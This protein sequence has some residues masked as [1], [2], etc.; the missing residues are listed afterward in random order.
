[1]TWTERHSYQIT[2]V[3]LKAMA[4]VNPNLA[5]PQATAES[6]NAS[7]PI[8][9]TNSVL[10]SEFDT[11]KEILRV[12]LQSWRISSL[13]KL[14]LAEVKQ[15]RYRQKLALSFLSITFSVEEIIYS[16]SYAGDS[17]RLM[18]EDWISSPKFIDKV[19]SPARRGLQNHFQWH[20]KQIK[21]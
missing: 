9:T 6:S 17:T 8:E 3:K 4:M 5:L 12:Q 14:I 18:K 20:I 7:K 10:I 11:V 16:S 2:M 21:K 15:A 13:E 19:W 1:M